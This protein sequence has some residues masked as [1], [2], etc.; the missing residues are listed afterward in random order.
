[1]G[2]VPWPLLGA[3]SNRHPWGA[4]LAALGSPRLSEPGRAVGQVPLLGHCQVCWALNRGL[5]GCYHPLPVLTMARVGSCVV[6]YPVMGKEREPEEGKPVLSSRN[7]RQTAGGLFTRVWWN[8]CASLYPFPGPPPNK[9]TFVLRTFGWRWQE[10][11]GW[12][13]MLLTSRRFHECESVFI[14]K[15]SKF[16]PHCRT[17]LLKLPSWY[18]LSL[19]SIRERLLRFEY[20]SPVCLA[21]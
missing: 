5:L 7:Y 18:L 15:V 19:G 20:P 8:T 13:S 3:V 10:L 1:M 12:F 16:L 2:R 6:V 14:D 9:D 11:S 21:Q 17:H 4:P